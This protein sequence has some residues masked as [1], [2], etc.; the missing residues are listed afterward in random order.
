M[1]SQR[2]RSATERVRDIGNLA[3]EVADGMSVKDARRL[4][5]RDAAAAWR[6][7]A[8]DRPEEVEPQKGIRRWLHR[9]KV[10]FRGVSNRSRVR[11]WSRSVA[12]SSKR[13][14]AAAWS[15]CASSFSTTSSVRPSR[16]SRASSALCR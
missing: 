12:A 3:R 10:I 11:I 14:P 5:D 7:L 6:V 4:L 15:I 2:R 8:R 13:S 16:N 9:A 1:A